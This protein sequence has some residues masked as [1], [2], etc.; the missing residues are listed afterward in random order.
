VPQAA[1]DAEGG[2]PTDGRVARR[3]LAP[4]T[5]RLSGRPDPVS[6][7]GEDL[8]VLH[9]DVHVPGWLTKRLVQDSRWIVLAE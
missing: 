4:G 8:L 9:L 2:H 6:P 5:G 1:P 7:T 3:G